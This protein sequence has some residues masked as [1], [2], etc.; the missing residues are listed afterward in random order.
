VTNTEREQRLERTMARSGYS[1]D[2]LIEVL[3]TAQSL[4]G[5]LSPEI[6]ERVATRLKMPPSRVLGVATFYHLFSF[7]PKAPHRAVVCLGTA[8]YAAGAK[9]LETLL[10]RDWPDWQIKVGRCLSSCGLA[11]VVV[12]N[13]DPQIRLTPERLDAHLREVT[14]NELR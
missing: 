12:C 4:Y 10:R 14:E 8:C 1:S 7:E 5:Y 6:L 13:G 3:H 2:A 11:P 9:K